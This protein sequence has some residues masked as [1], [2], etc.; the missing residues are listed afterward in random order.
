MARRPAGKAG[1]WYAAVAVQLLSDIQRF[2]SGNVY[3]NSQNVKAVIVPHAGYDY[4]GMVAGAS[5]SAL[6][7]ASNEI[8][9][10]FVIGPSH[11]TT[12]AAGS[13]YA[14]NFDSYET[15][16]GQLTVD[17]AGEQWPKMNYHAEKEEHSLEMQMPFIKH[18]FPEATIV[19]LVV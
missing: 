13:L 15:P 7:A 18:L 17:L 16:L 2:L 9:R 12:Y 19:P 3:Q 4:S 14:S 6:A 5:Y 1:T 8:R 10:V 11:V